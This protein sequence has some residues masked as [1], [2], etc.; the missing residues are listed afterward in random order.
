MKLEATGKANKLHYKELS[1][2]RSNKPSDKEFKFDI[3][4]YEGY[5][6]RFNYYLSVDFHTGHLI[7]TKSSGRVHPDRILDSYLRDGVPY[8]EALPDIKRYNTYIIDFVNTYFGLDIVT[9][10]EVKLVSIRYELVEHISNLN[11]KILTHRRNGGKT[12]ELDHQL[13]VLGSAYLL[14]NARL[15]VLRY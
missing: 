6:S 14:V 15:R 5:I 13:Q 2:Y 3:D 8:E 9:D 1:W 4:V 12:P 7:V 10:D 11:T